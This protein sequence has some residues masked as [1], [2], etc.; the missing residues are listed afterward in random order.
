MAKRT[1]TVQDIAYVLNLSPQ[2]VYK[3]VKDGKLRHVRLGRKIV[4]SEKALKEYLGEENYEEI[5]GGIEEI[6][7]KPRKRRRKSER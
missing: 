4:I 3:W 5:F 2:T 7:R 6:P 1:F